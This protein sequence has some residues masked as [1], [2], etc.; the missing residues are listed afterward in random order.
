[1]LLTRHYTILLRPP[2]TP[3]V[4][5][6]GGIYTHSLTYTPTHPKQTQ[7]IT[8]ADDITISTMYNTIKQ[9]DT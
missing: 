7:L 5:M 4:D 8:Y 2:A 3:T 1:M 6:N 9:T